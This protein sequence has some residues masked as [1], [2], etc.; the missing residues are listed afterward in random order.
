MSDCQACALAFHLQATKVHPAHHSQKAV[1]HQT[2]ARQA[3]GRLMPCQV[4]DLLRSCKE[5][6][7]IRHNLL[8]W[9]R[10]QP[11]NLPAAFCHIPSASN[12]H[13]LMC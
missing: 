1:P 10:C 7:Y 6:A 8:K 9:A 11:Q 4:D 12:P 13:G 5:L 2:I 3:G